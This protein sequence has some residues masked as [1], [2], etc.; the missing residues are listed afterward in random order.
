MVAHTH[1]TTCFTSW[2]ASSSGLC[3]SWASSFKTSFGRR[4]VYLLKTTCNNGRYEM[5]N[6]NTQFHFY[7]IIYYFKLS[8][9]ICLVT[10]DLILVLSLSGDGIIFDLSLSIHLHSQGIGCLFLSTHLQR[11]LG[12]MDLWES[13][14]ISKV[15]QRHRF[16]VKNC[17]NGLGAD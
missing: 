12:H 14:S 1:H 17:L 5:L 8:L 15:L 3:S 11:E 4:S 7:I 10:A 9:E 16:H 13:S 6:I 2:T